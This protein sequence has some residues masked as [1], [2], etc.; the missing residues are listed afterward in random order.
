MR[1][2]ANVTYDFTGEVVLITGGA[3]G[4]GANHARCFAA[5]GADVVIADIGEPMNTI[6]YP[7][8][9]ADELNDL[10]AEIESLGV[11]CQAAICD[12]RDRAQVKTMVD[13]AIAEFGRIDILINNAGVESLPSVAEMTEAEWDEMIDTLLKGTFLCSQAVGAHMTERGKGR[14]VTTGSIASTTGMPRQAHYCAAKHGVVGFTKALAIELAE[15]DVTVNVV[16]PGGIDTPM[17]QGLLVS[18][19]AEWME[20]LAEYGGPFNLFNPEEMLDSQE[21]TNAMLWLAS[22][23][24][25]YVT[26]AVLTVDA[27]FTIK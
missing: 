8:A 20:K 6:P 4:Q 12:V 22:D 19:Q 21:I 13:D 23:A 9:T 18:R 27:G 3:R 26:G 1:E 17:T 15:F 7:L 10:A 14:I 24:A 16:C 5:A 25:R 11:R 2:V